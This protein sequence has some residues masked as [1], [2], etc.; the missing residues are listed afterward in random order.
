MSEVRILIIENDPASRTAL[1]S[2]LKTEDWQVEVVA[3]PEEA[4]DRLRQVAWHLVLVDVS[5]SHLH[6][7][8][9]ELLKELA[10]AGGSVRVLFL[11]PSIVEEVA[12]LDLERQKLPYCTRP[13]HLDDLLEKVSELLQS[14]GVI[15]QPLRRVRELAQSARP[16]QDFQQPGQAKAEMFVSRK[17]YL[18][19]DEE[20]L[21][22]QEEEEEAQRRKKQQE[23]KE[24]REKM[25]R[26]P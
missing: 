8:L 2:V 21:R 20:E 1:A 25:K 5:I 18:D 23:E 14:A 4:L 24:R 11:V 15:H 10:L 16:A 22:R 13:I 7:P 6:G 17:G 3:A 19:Y 12:R 9:F 26:Q